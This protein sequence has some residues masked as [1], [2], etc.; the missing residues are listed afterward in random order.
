MRQY[1]YVIALTGGADCW[2]RVLAKSAWEMDETVSWE[3]G[4]LSALLQAGWRPVRE[5]PMSG[6]E[7]G[8]AASILVLERDA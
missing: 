7:M 8:Y 6:G 1:C 5:T 2:A 3:A 4:N